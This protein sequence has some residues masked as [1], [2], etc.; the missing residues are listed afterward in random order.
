MFTDL[1]Q[2]LRLL[3]KNPGFSAL[4]VIVLAVGVGANTAIFSIVHGVLLKPLPFADA[5][6]LVSIANIIRGEEQFDNS[7]P[8]FVDWH[9][10]S[11]TIDRM[12]AYTSNR[13]TMTGRGD[14]TALQVANVTSDLFPL[15]G[16][17]PLLGRSLN[18]ADDAK[19]AQ[20][21]AVISEST[22]EHRFGRSPSILWQ[23]VTLDGVRFTIVGVMPAAFQFPIQVEPV[24]AWMPVGALTLTS[25]WMAQRG[26]HFIRV[27]GHLRPETTIEQA[28]AELAT[29]SANL[30]AA[31]PESN[32]KRSAK[33]RPLI[34]HL[35]REYR[36][37]LT[38]L[39]GAVAAVLLIACANVANL[40][41][42]RG[43]TRQ[44]EMAIRAAMVRRGAV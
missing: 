24:E 39:L 3:I 37:G 20:P 12:A 22:W 33:A 26:A 9:Q 27:I 34:D 32:G 7:F 35:V 5:S 25:Q 2:A 8:D 41:L 30:A 40:L 36:L 1:R 6:R 31:Y 13:V 4:V 42:A 21:I 11:K 15:L 43:T 16:A 28:N 29:I 17:T 10:Q 38:V 18:A 14:A 44:K 19:G 23:A